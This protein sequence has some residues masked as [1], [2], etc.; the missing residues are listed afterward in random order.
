MSTNLRG[1]VANAP[2]LVPPNFVGDCVGREY[3]MPAGSKVDNT[4]FG[5]ADA[6]GRIVIPAGTVV[7]RTIAER[8]ALAPLGPAADTDVDIYI[9]AFDVTDALVLDDVELLRPF[10]G[11]LIKENFLPT[12]LASLTS[13]IQTAIRARYTCT[14]GV[15]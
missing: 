3:L 13:A 11:L 8:N 12:P 5:A 15:S 4:A 9:T 6:L 7:G 1:M 14:T 10:A 2:T